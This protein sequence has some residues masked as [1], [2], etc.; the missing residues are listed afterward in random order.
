VVGVPLPMISYGGT[1]MV[2]LLGLRHTDVAP[3]ATASSSEFSGVRTGS[4]GSISSWSPSSCARAVSA[5]PSMSSAP[6]QDFIA[7]MADT[8]SFKKRQLRK[9]LKAAQ[10]QPAIIEAMDRPA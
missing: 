7:H 2:T 1:S 6:S 8:S 4:A 9:L 5:P 10:S 3:L